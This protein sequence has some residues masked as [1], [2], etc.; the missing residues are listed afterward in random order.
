MLGGASRE[1][2]RPE[3]TADASAC[4]RLVTPFQASL[5]DLVSPSYRIPN[6]EA[7]GYCQFVPSGQGARRFAL[8]LE[9]RGASW[10]ALAFQSWAM[11]ELRTVTS[12]TN[13]CVRSVPIWDRIVQT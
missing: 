10:K 13:G 2:F 1:A 6:A 8:Y 11:A 4:Q 5:Q 9:P 12:P 3:G 7:L